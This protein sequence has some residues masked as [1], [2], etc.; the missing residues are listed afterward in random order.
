MDYRKNITLL[1]LMFIAAAAF[2][3]TPVAIYP[4]ETE[5][6]QACVIVNG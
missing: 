4:T 6:A 5:Q 2:T 3:Q 1:A